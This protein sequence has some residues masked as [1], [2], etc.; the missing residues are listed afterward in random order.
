MGEQ[1]ITNLVQRLEAVTSRLEKVE[2][3]IQSGG[4]APAGGA[5]A[6]GASSGA[7]GAAWVGEYDAFFGENI[8]KLVELTQK[9]GNDELKAQ[10]VAFEAAL[11]AHRE[12]LNVA[13]S[14]TS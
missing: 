7:S 3:Q 5:A 4:A 13:S 8:P 6:G 12:F 14:V 1:A 2:N 10:V 9:L 11:K